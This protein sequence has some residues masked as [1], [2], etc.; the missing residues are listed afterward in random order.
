[1]RCNAHRDDY[2]L[3]VLCVINTSDAVREYN[4]SYFMK[5]LKHVYQAD[6]Y[7]ERSLQ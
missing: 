1:M 6:V 5:T 7:N 4:I 3:P 2:R